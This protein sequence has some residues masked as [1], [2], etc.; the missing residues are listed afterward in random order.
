MANGADYSGP[1]DGELDASFMTGVSTFLHDNDLG[2]CY[3][4]ILR[5]GDLWSLTT[6]T[7]GETSLSLSV[8]NASG[9][10]RVQSALRL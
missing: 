4:P 10:T 8:N 2:N 7:G 1:G 9:L 3:W 6:L 5:T